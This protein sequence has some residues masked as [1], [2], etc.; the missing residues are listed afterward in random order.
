MI[1]SFTFHWAYDYCCQL[2]HNPSLSD[3]VVVDPF[4]IRR[5][6]IQDGQ[7]KFFSRSTVYFLYVHRCDSGKQL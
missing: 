5:V 1:C 3:S 7:K 2:S 6:D 4:I